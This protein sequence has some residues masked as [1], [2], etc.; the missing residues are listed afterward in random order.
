LQTWSQIAV[1]SVGGALGVNARFWLGVL[2]NRWAGSEGSPAF[3]WATVTINITGSFAIGLLAIFLAHHWPHPLGRLFLVTG[4]L[5]GYT[6][7]SSFT[8]ESL[9]LWEDGE[10]TLSAANTFGSV[11]GGLAAVVLGVALGRALIGLPS[12]DEQPVTT[13]DV[14]RRAD[15]LELPT[16][17]FL[18]EGRES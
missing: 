9:K 4:F 12:T 15:G 13:P 7:F 18:E 8:Y 1:L 14:E 10:K 2:I 11:I 17:A 6:T 3:P 5:G 16:E